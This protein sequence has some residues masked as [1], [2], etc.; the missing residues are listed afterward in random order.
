MNKKAITTLL[1]GDEKYIIGAIINAYLH[2]KFIDKYNLKIDMTVMLDVKFAQYKDE[3][4][5]YYDKIFMI[6]LDETKISSKTDIRRYASVMKYLPSKALMFNLTEYDKVLF[7]DVDFLP[8]K[9]EFYTIFDLDTP[10]FYSEEINCD[11]F[12][13]I[14]DDNVF[15]DRKTNQKYIDNKEYNK[16]I[17]NMKNSINATLMLIKP[18]EKDYEDFLLFKKYAEGKYGV[19]TKKGVDEILILGFTVLIKKENIHCIPTSFRNK[20]GIINK[21]FLGINFASMIKPWLRLPMFQWAEEN[22]WHVIAKKAL[23][24]SVLFTNLYISKLLENFRELTKNY[25]SGKNIRNP[26]IFETQGK[27]QLLELM[28]YLMDHESLDIENDTSIIKHIMSEAQQ[29]HSHIFEKL[30]DNYSEIITVIE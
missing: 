1:F 22:I 16:I 5:Q 9:K 6:E 4:S 18:S 2:K 8:I 26:K 28:K 29:I 21:N 7:T 24:K 23:K 17:K 13:Q 25:M 19:E 3:L 12:N 10:A 11:K 15:V 27:K 14:Y 20:A 30:N